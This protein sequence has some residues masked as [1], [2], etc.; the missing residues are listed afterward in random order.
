MNTQ[1]M[2][3]PTLSLILPLIIALVSVLALAVPAYANG[4]DGDQVVFGNNLELK[5]GDEVGGSVAVF[6]GNLIAPAESTIDGDLVVFG[7]NAEVGGDVTGNV[8]VIG[9]NLT[10]GSTAVIEGD[11]AIIGG[12]ANVAEGAT[13]EGDFKD[14]HHFGFDDNADNFDSQTIPPLPP[15]PPVSPVAPP[16]PSFSQ[17]SDDGANSVIEKIFGFVAYVVGTIVTLLVLAVISWLVATFMPEQMKVV[18]DAMVG[19]TAMSFGIGL[20]TWV[21][22]LV[23]GFILLI[24]ICLAFI[25]LIAYILLGIATLFGWIVAG[26]LIGERLLAAIGRPYPSYVG[27]TV[28]GVVI[29]TLVSQMPV[30]E[31]LPCIGFIPWLLGMLLGIIVSITAL[32]AVILTRFGT[33]PYPQPDNTFNAGPSTGFTAPPSGPRPPRSSGPSPLDRSEAELMAKIKQALAEADTIPDQPASPAAPAPAAEPE[34]EP[35]PVDDTPG[36]DAPAPASPADDEGID[37]P[38]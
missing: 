35:E 15:V 38:K 17:G 5:P 20:I 31:M 22:A 7:G 32:G 36:D 8:A 37:L 24:T 13:I 4:P 29:L 21:V 27:S 28:V 34:T 18:G 33:R 3:H 23:L 25:P 14:L 9:G 11:V 10:L 12:Q 19:Y 16:A 2:L 30:I 6:G 1:K 26:Q